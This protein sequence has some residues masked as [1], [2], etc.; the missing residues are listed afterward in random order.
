VKELRSVSETCKQLLSLK[1]DLPIQWHDRYACIFGMSQCLLCSVYP[2]DEEMQLGFDVDN[3]AVCNLEQYGSSPHSEVK[4]DGDK[5]D[6]AIG[7]LLAGEC[8]MFDELRTDATAQARR[9]SQ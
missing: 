8:M 4:H 3:K 6:G 9:T 7:L 2:V 5:N 1:K